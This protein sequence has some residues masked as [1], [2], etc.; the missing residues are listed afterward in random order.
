MCVVDWSV[1]NWATVFGTIGE[2]AIAFVIYY[3][4]EA[5]R[6]ATF[7]GNVQSAKFLKD[8]RK[9]YEMYLS[10]GPSGTPL[11][12][13]AEEFMK[14][15]NE[16]ANLRSKCDL[17]W[18]NID[19]LQFALRRSPLHWNLPAKWFPQA[20]VSLWVM[21]GLYVR[22]LQ[23]IR[24]PDAHDYAE[25]AVRKSIRKLV[26]RKRLWGARIGPITIYGDHNE[27]VVEISEQMILAMHDDLD[28]P[29][30]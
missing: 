14:K 1:T 30:K 23:R 7:L 27:P 18:S 11:K 12:T 2:F 10:N 26:W 19:R 16:D 25:K 3:E 8:R 5:N 15:I 6:I 22:H 20:L 13:R 28:A 29:F 24:L 4:L 21:T 9:I 17:Q